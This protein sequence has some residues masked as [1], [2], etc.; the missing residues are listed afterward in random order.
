[1]TV[2]GPWSARNVAVDGRLTPSD[3]QRRFA[4]DTALDLIGGSVGVRW[5][6]AET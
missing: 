6:I 2:V 3:Q 5:P 4:G 1:M